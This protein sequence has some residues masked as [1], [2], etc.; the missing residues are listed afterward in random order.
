MIQAKAGNP[1]GDRAYDNE[2]L[3]A[4][5]PQEATEMIAPH[6]SNR[7]KPQTQSGHRLA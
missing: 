5:L 4:E 2:Q 6:R 1:I 3:A 7:V